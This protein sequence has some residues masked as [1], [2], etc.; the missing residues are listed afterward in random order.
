MVQSAWFIVDGCET[1]CNKHLK[2]SW[3][4]LLDYIIYQTKFDS[5][6]NE[7]VFIIVFW[8]V[9][10]HLPEKS[11]ESIDFPKTILWFLNCLSWNEVVK[12]LVDHEELS[13][14]IN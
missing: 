9:L 1:G 4:A 5:M 7:N 3:S 11:S 12:D 14:F 6:M 2:Q 10:L 8:K 13:I